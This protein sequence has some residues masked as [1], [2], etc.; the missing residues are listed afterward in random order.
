MAALVNYSSSD[1]DTDVSSNEIENAPSRP[2]LSL[3]EEFENKYRSSPRLLDDPVFHQGRKRTFAHVEGAWT[4]QS[5]IEVKL[6]R[7][8]S[9]QLQQILK[10]EI[11]IEERDDGTPK[12]NDWVPLFFSEL[13]LAKPLHLTL[14]SM[15]CLDYESKES[16]RVQWKQTLSSA[17]FQ[18]FSIQ[19]GK[20]LYLVNEQ[21]TRGFL[22][23]RIHFDEHHLKPL[24][25]KINDLNI[26]FGMQPLRPDFIPH[27]SFCWR[28]TNP[29]ECE[30]WSSAISL[31]EVPSKFDNLV[32]AIEDLLKSNNTNIPVKS[33]KLSTGGYLDTL[34]LK[35]PY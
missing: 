32:S 14:S 34:E 2:K 16:F 35:E 26:S 28:K 21:Q 23:W 4:T 33:V 22:A 5:F 7:S 24:C 19:L 15:D 9:S 29:K 31:Y 25:Q 13:G 30:A 18:P 20:V 17:H 3:P 10:S 8:L 6:T 12:S 11:A 27:I 1:S